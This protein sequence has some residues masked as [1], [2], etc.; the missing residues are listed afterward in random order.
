MALH[1][2]G[3]HFTDA[4]G[5]TIRLLGA[6]RSGTEYACIQGWGI[7][8]GPNDAASVAVM[9]SWHMNAVRVPLNEDCWLNINGVN[10][11]YGGTTY[12]NAIVNYVNLLHQYNMYV[13]L[14]L[15]WSAPGTQRSTGQMNMADA[16][17]AP[18]FWQS[19]ATTFKN[20]PA[21]VFDLYNEPWGIDWNC[22]LN[23]CTSPGF[24]TAG[25]QSL[26]NAVR[27]TGATQPIMVGG[28]DW[29]NDLS[30]WLSHKPTD[31]ANALAASLHMYNFNACVNLSC[32]TNIVA[33]VARSVPIV[34]GEM[35][36][37]DCSHAFIDVFMPWA[38][39]T[40][41]SYTA[42]AWDQFGCGGGG[43]SVGGLINDY[44]GTPNNFGVGFKA[45]LLLVNP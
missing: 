3:N 36:E 30:Q 38:D 13:I 5:R 35:G 23:G 45:H 29:S 22:W 37:N 20:D 18:A 11:A 21:V 34:T 16:D 42:W 31:P 33:T 40:G 8:S 19:V 39:A 4:S 14:D 32:W 17:H 41:I 15:H 44:S 25:M 1:V 2:S 6:D 10:P 12:R 7:F 26:V 9:Q 28:L 27:S 43:V 24:Q